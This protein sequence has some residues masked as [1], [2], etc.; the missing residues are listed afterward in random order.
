MGLTRQGVEFLLSAKNRGVDFTSTL[1]IGR[2]NLLVG[3][4]ELKS[5]LQAFGVNITKDR[6]TAILEENSGYADGLFA[7]FGAKRVESLDASP[8][9]GAS[10]EHDLNF[11]IP[12]VLKQQF[13]TVIDGGSLEHIFDVKTAFR[14]IME[15]VKLGGHLLT[16]NPANNCLGHGFFQFSPE[17]FY[18]VLS[19]ENGFAIDRVLLANLGI[20]S[21]WY[22]IADR[23]ADG[24]QRFVSHRTVYV[25]VVAK[26][27]DSVVPF[28]VV[29]QQGDYIRA[30]K[31]SS[32]T[33]SEGCG[34]QVKALVKRLMAH[35]PT[36]VKR[37]IYGSMGHVQRRSRTY[38]TGF[39]KV[40]L[41]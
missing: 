20:R 33:A 29:P 30:W 26:K 28:S 4:R 27:I 3:S 6:A 40:E 12:E 8:Y 13:T 35:L 34:T 11:P 31:L 36:S 14:N 10:I 21:E 19:P 16:I 37:A 41:S 18:R 9:E 38:R 39:R 32:G 25:C 7:L 22:E 5:T 17:L 2:Q 15:C 23:A 24:H 1:T